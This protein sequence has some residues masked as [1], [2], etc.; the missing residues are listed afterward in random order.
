MKTPKPE[1]AILG[2]AFMQISRV[3]SYRNRWICDA[4]VWEILQHHFPSFRNSDVFTRP[5]MIRAIRTTCG[6]CIQHFAA[7]MNDTGIFNHTYKMECPVLGGGRRQVQFYF[8]T[9]PKTYT[10]RPVE[11]TGS[12]FI[13][14]GHS[15]SFRIGGLRTSLSLST[16][17]KRQKTTDP[18]INQNDRESTNQ[19][20]TSQSTTNQA[21]TNDPDPPGTGGPEDLRRSYWDSTEARLLFAPSSDGPIQEILLERIQILASVANEA[22]GWRKIVFGHDIG[23]QELIWLVWLSKR[24]SLQPTFL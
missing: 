7:G 18:T 1:T 15:Q 13:S 23:N 21:T 24:V 8:F 16:P 9:E 4:K 14:S 22:E 11:S 19:A 20:T 10:T 2:D 3:P 12:R 17:N 6:E 5:K